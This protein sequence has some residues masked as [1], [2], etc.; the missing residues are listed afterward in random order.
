MNLK[1]LFFTIVLMLATYALRS[2]VSPDCLNAIPICNDTPVNAGTQGYGQDDFNGA[3]FSGCLEQT[4][5]GAI[6]SNSAWY[7]FRT[8]ASGQLGFNIGFDID[9]DWDFALYQTDDCGNLG[10]PVRCNFFDNSDR[11]A[12]MGVGEDP[13]GSTS[14]VLY[15]DWLQVNPGEDYYLLIN[16]F[17][18]TNSGFSI[19]FTGAIFQTNPYDALDCSIISNLL[20]PPVAACDNEVVVLDATTPNALNYTWYQDT[21]SGYQQLAGVN[22][23]TY[24]VPASAFYRV[25]VATPSGNIYSDVQ[26]GFSTAP[27]TFPLSDEVFCTQSGSLDLNAKDVEALGGQ[28]P[29]LF[30]VS[31]HPSLN[32]ANLGTNALPKNYPLVPGTQSVYVR[33]TS[34]ANGKCYD[35]SQQF[36]LQV[37]APPILDFPTEVPICEDG[38]AVTIG[39]T[40]PDPNSTYTWD[41]G[42]QTPTITVSGS[43]AYTLTVTNTQGGNGCSER[44][45]VNVVISEPPGISD[46]IISDLQENNTVEV[47]TDVVGTFEYQLD[48]GPFQSGN[49]FAN[50]SPGIHTVTVR[51]LLGCGAVSEDISVVGFPKF[52]TPNGDGNNDYWHIVGIQELNE[53]VVFVYDR[54]GKLLKQLYPNSPGWDGTFNGRELPSS[55]YWFRLSYLNND[56]QRVDARH[57]NSHFALKR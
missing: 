22:T 28:D 2:Q 18:N 5:T 29:G 33:T 43:G 8:G 36:T 57:L 19:Q 16:N 51:D 10:D 23:P 26:V 47:V 34:V 25:E 53:P 30:V 40:T 14:T 52:F 21:G 13:T 7:R 48:S 27:T 41:S 4:L 39:D 54:Y 9:E 15:E 55:D 11:E 49:R 46:V 32:D 42:E 1:G 35:I 20:G 3:Q 6:E 37:A 56:G 45:T 38:G 50:V 17:S 31:Y 44:W 12:Y 24:Q